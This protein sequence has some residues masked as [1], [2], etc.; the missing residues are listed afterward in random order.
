MRNIYKKTASAIRRTIGAAVA[1][2]ISLPVILPISLVYAADGTQATFTVT[3]AV[4]SDN[5]YQTF[6]YRLVPMTTGAPMPSGSGQ[7]GYVFTIT[8]MGEHVTESI[9][10]GNPGVFLYELSC[11]T[12]DADGLTIDRR[13]YNIEVTVTDDS[14]MYMIVYIQTGVKLPE[15][16]FEHIVAPSP[17]PT[18]SPIHTPG[19]TPTPAPEHTPSPT[20]SPGPEHTPSPEPTP[21]PHPEHTPSPEP[22]PTPHPGHHTPGPAH[23]PHPGHNP[24]TGGSGSTGKP[25]GQNSPQTG[26]FS[27]PLLWAGLIALSGTAFIIVVVIERR[28]RRRRSK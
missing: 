6:A 28:L 26:D 20:P 18:P 12:G 27:N 24:G 2:L 3:Q 13:T 19:P 21:T 16:V 5:P 1:V 10:F 7:D 15:I 11:I 17:S 23:T 14:Q 22:T 25:G 8:G 9:S 4:I